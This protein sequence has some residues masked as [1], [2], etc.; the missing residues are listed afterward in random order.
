MAAEHPLQGVADFPHCGA[1]PGGINGQGQQVGVTSGTNFECRQRR[2]HG[3]LITGG[4]DVAKSDDLLRAYLVVVHIEDILR[5]LLGQSVLVDTHD[6]ILAT[7]HP[8]LTPSGGILDT[9][10][11]HPGLHRHCHATDGLHF[12]D[13]LPRL[14][15][16]RLGE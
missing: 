4:P 10:F 1:C 2:V 6:D 7:I 11:G 3:V 16:Q 15:G 12:F 13:Q 9:Q 5:I 8:S 14:G